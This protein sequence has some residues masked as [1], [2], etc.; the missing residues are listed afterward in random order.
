MEELSDAPANFKS[1]FLDI[2]P[3]IYTNKLAEEE[4]AYIH[5]LSVMSQTS[6]TRSTESCF[7]D[8]EP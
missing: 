6:V 2:L 5:E 8:L 1:G 7:T 4:L 3:S